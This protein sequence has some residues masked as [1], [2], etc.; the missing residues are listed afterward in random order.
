MAMT[1]GLSTWLGRA[2]SIRDE[3]TGIRSGQLRQQAQDA[4][5]LRNAAWI[6]AYHAR[7]QEE[8][9]QAMTRLFIPDAQQPRLAA[10]LSVL[11]EAGYETIPFDVCGEWQSE[12]RRARRANPGPRVIMLGWGSKGNRP[13]LGYICI[14]TED[15]DV[16]AMTAFEPLKGLTFFGRK[17]CRIHTR[18]LRLEGIWVHIRA[19]CTIER[20]RELPS[21]MRRHWSPREGLVVSRRGEEASAFLERIA[22]AEIERQV[23]MMERAGKVHIPV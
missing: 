9:Q 22:V 3:V 5:A 10:T 7:P 23:R 4:A 1:D 20:W 17:R 15:G 21:H 6:D 19:T 11:R 8:M 12:Y 2:A 13:A 14:G 16:A 18:L